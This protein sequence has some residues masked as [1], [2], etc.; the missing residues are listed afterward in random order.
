MCV[1]V[2][3]LRLHGR[4]FSSSTYFTRALPLPSPAWVKRIAPATDLLHI[5]YIFIKLN[6]LFSIILPMKFVIPCSSRADRMRCL[7]K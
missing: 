1:K 7:L 4:A 5:H 6:D 2:R 3:H